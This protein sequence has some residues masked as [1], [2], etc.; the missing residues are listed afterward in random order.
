M[1]TDAI[2]TDTIR[3]AVDY[4]NNNGIDADD[5]I[6]AFQNKEGKYVT[7]FKRPKDSKG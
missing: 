5:I 4:L 2:I 7:L 3:D 1:K 6:T